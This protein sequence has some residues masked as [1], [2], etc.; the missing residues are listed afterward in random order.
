MVPAATLVTIITGA[1]ISLKA[2]VVAES[3]QLARKLI[4]I[5][6]LEQKKMKR[7]R[8][9][10]RTFLFRAAVFVVMCHKK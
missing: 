10:S 2:E 5:H 8:T 9:Q 7:K 4:K 3:L 1:L 6:A